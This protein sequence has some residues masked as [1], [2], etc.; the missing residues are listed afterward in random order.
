MPLLEIGADMY[1]NTE[2]NC[3]VRKDKERELT[4]STI[5]NTAY[6]LPMKRVPGM[7]CFKNFYYSFGV[8]I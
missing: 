7:T 2:D 6:P 1:T 8:R 3:S 4:K 5:G